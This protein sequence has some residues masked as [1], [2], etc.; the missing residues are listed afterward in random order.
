[1]STN[2]LFEVRQTNVV[3]LRPAR[4]SG[5]SRCPQGKTVQLRRYGF[6]LEVQEVLD[7]G[8]DRSP[9]GWLRRE[10]V[11]ATTGRTRS[12]RPTRYSPSGTT[13]STIALR[14]DAPCHLV[15]FERTVMPPRWLTSRGKHRRA[16]SASSRSGR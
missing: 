1:V 13:V 8:L 3:G 9:A 7:A 14:R 16:G 5:S 11:A 12:H 10:S 15:P 2:Q 4:E 6:R